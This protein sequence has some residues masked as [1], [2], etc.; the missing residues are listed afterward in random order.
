MDPRLRSYIIQSRFYGVYHIG[1]ITLDWGLITGLVEKWHPETHTFH[2]PIGKMTITLQDV[3]IILELCIHGLPIT[4]TCDIDW[5]LLCYELLGMT[6]PT[7]EIKGSVI[8]TRWLCHQFSHPPVDLDDAT[9]EQ[10]ARAFILGL[11]GSTLFTDKKG[12]HIHMCYLPLLRDLT[13]TSMYSWGSVVL[14]H[15]YRE[16]CRASLDGATDIAGCVTLLQV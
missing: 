5:S 9:L 2:L 16:L 15:L 6:P 4:G 7:S 10:Y 13:Q 11:I 1:H 12:T 14:A 8:L 3:A